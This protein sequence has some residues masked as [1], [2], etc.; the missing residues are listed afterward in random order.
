VLLVD[1]DGTN[2]AGK[3]VA[4]GSYRYVMDYSRNGT[5]STI[6]KKLVLVRK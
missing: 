3:P 1:W 6:V 5:N 4:S 2:D